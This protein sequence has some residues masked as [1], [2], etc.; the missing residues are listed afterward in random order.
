[1]ARRDPSKYKVE[2]LVGATGVNN[3][4]NIDYKITDLQ[5]GLVIYGKQGG[6]LNQIQLQ[7]LGGLAQKAN[8]RLGEPSSI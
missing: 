5:T 7:K 3:K 2:T 1:M 4:Y 6:S 8:N